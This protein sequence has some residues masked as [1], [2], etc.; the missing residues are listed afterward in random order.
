LRTAITYSAGALVA[1]RAVSK[2]MHADVGAGREAGQC[3]A[4]F[5]AQSQHADQRIQR[6]RLDDAQ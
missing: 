4:V 2:L 1:L 3:A 5:S 6:P